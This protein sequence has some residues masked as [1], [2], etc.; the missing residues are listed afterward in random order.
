MYKH[1]LIAIDGSE[2][3]QTALRQ[4]V[5]LAKSLDAKVTIVTVSEPWHSYA[6]GEIAMPFPVKQYQDSIAKWALEILAK[7]K[8]VAD[9]VGVNSATVHIKEDYPA[10]GILSVAEKQDC[11]LI[12]MASHGRRGLSRIILGSQANQVVTHSQVPVLICR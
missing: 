4:G 11:D 3:A 10:D 9:D 7:A 12:V 5:A 2:L 1:L 6:P 8:A